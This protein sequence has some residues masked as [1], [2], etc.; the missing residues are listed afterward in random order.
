MCI[1]LSDKL[2]I[3]EKKGKKK[4]KKKAGEGSDFFPERVRVD[5]IRGYSKKKGVGITYFHA[6]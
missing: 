6:N 4:K 2:K 3:F 1:I 5:K